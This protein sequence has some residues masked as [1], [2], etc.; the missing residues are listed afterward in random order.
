[1]EVVLL[2]L[3]VDKIFRIV[4]W[5]NKYFKMVKIYFKLKILRWVDKLFLYI[6]IFY[7]FFDNYIFIIYYVRYSFENVL[8]VNL[9]I[10][11]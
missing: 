4:W 1:M 8:F 10:N 11:F 5:F 6:R 3:W 9:W 7:F 2:Y